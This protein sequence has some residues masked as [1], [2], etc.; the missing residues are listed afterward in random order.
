M[1]YVVIVVLAILSLGPAASAQQTAAQTVAARGPGEPTLRKT[2]EFTY[3]VLMSID[4]TKRR[5]ALHRVPPDKQYE[6][7]KVHLVTMIEQHQNTLTDRQVEFLETTIVELQ[8]RDF[9]R[10]Q[11]RRED[12]MR[13]WQG[14]RL[15]RM[16]RK[17][18]AKALR[19]L[20]PA[21]LA[22]EIFSL[23]Q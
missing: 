9:V 2:R 14:D 13:A 19:E 21:P 12:V 23:S 1:R 6:L 8:P 15:G 4:S 22:R 20:F 17:T 7:I 5:A 10:R 18:D 16:Y 3:D 11:M